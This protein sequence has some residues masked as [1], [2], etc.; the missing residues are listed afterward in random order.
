[1][2]SLA[3]SGEREREREREINTEMERCEG[4][5]IEKKKTNNAT[6]GR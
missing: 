3:G 5:K 1:M 4:K 6:Y 2:S